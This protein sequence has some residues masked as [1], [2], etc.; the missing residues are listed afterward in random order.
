MT[1]SMKWVMT[2]ILA[3]VLSSSGA[4]Y[5][6]GIGIDKDIKKTFEVGEG[7]TLFVDTDIGS[8]QVESGSGNIVDIHVYRTVRSSSERK[9]EKI[10]SDFNIEFRQQG[11]DVYVTAEYKKSRR[12]FSWM[13]N[14][15]RV[16]F[17]IHPTATLS[18]RFIQWPAPSTIVVLWM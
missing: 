11:N 17:A 10:L 3:V 6:E 5:V 1:L 14:R 18:F 2:L 8:I 13:G 15:L 7:G 16:N 4:C 9:A 12:L